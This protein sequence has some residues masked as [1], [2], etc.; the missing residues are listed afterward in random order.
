MCRRGGR[1]RFHDVIVKNVE[2]QDSRQNVLGQGE[3]VRGTI[4]ARMT[5][6]GRLVLLAVL[7]SWALAGGAPRADA[8]KFTPLLPLE[9]APRSLEVRFQLAETYQSLSAWERAAAA[10]AEIAALAPEDRRARLAYGF[11]L[12]RI[13]R[14]D[15]AAQ[16]YAVALRLEGAQPE[17]LKAL[18]EIDAAL[19]AKDS[20]RTTCRSLKPTAVRYRPGAAWR[21]LERLQ[22]EEGGALDRLYS[23]LAASGQW[24]DA[25][26]QARLRTRLAPSSPTGFVNLGMALEMLGNLGGA[27]EAYRRAVQLDGARA[28][29]RLRFG[30]VLLAL[31]D[32]AAA[33]E[34][35][36]ALAFLDKDR[37]AQ[38]FAVPELSRVLTRRP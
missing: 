33:F 12:R 11:V 38:L 15:D 17:A 22:S 34:Q 24:A 35:Y 20:L 3:A 16:Q 4:V 37:A 9:P 14:L 2:A 18:V 28:D 23:A 13:G 25:A 19:G 6:R 10:Y 32:A 5:Q 26:E 29:T 1:R 36:Q 31:G 30:F 27:A 21:H 7:G 8:A